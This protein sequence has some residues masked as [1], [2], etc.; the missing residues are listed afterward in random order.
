TAAEG[1]SP[2][3]R[4]APTERQDF[5]FTLVLLVVT[6]SFHT[7]YFQKRIVCH[8]PPP[9]ILVLIQSPSCSAAP[10][11]DDRMPRRCPGHPQTGQY[12]PGPHALS[13]RPGL[14]PGWRSQTA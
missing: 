13:L 11:G 3:L 1:V 9:R 6:F 10:V 8:K 4:G 2:R 5:D 7:F 14:C 12:H